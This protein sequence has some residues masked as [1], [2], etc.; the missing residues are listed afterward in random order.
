MP[1][2]EQHNIYRLNSFETRNAS[3]IKGDGIYANNQNYCKAG[4][5]KPILYF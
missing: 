1:E 2:K 5:L 3:G 4:L